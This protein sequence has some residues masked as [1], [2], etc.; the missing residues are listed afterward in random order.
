MNK[1]VVNAVLRKHRILTLLSS[2]TIES[3]GIGVKSLDFIPRADKVEH[4]GG[5]GGGIRMYGNAVIY[6]RESDKQGS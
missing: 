4:P 1:H 6:V 3:N 2:P 5:E